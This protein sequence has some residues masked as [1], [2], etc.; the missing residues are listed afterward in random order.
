[1][2]ILREVTTLLSTFQVALLGV[3]FL[4]LSPTS[5]LLGWHRLV[6]L[7]VFQGGILDLDLNDAFHL[8][9]V[10]GLARD[11]IYRHNWLFRLCSTYWVFKILSKLPWGHALHLGVKI[12]RVTRVF[13]NYRDHKVGELEASFFSNTHAHGRV[14]WQD[15]VRLV[16]EWL[17]STIVV[18]HVANTAF[19][20]LV[21][22]LIGVANMR[23]LMLAMLHLAWDIIIDKWTHHIV[24]LKAFRLASVKRL[25]VSS[26]YKFRASMGEIQL[27]FL[28]LNLAVPWSFFFF[29]YSL[30][31]IRWLIWMT[32]G[33]FCRSI[34]LQTINLSENTHALSW[35]FILDRLMLW[36]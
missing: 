29:N 30:T 20:V 16:N 5:A 34:I 35:A 14:W 7:I 9:S 24:H 19:L 2:T 36:S 8:L 23:L 3:W 22:H 13:F 32:S 25:H 26:S 31:I 1:M 33:V 17:M 11:A 4:C 6:E 28:I 15:S 10:I 27:I 12:V 21:D 18:T